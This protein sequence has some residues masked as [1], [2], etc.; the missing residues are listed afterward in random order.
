MQ[1]P[2]VA[3]RDEARQRLEVFGAASRFLAG[4]NVVRMAD[5]QAL[6]LDVP[7]PGCFKV[8]NAIGRKENVQ[9]K[10]TVLELDKVFAVYNCR[11]IGITE[12]KSQLCKGANEL[13]SVFR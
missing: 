5:R 7:R 10:W 8:L 11:Q 2:I 3:K 13:F 1:V 4:D 6:H 12:I 9:V